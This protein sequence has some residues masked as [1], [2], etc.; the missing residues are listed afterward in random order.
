VICIS[1][2]N[3]H[4]RC[5]WGIKSGPSMR[6]VGSVFRLEFRGFCLCP[7]VGRRK[8]RCLVGTSPHAPRLEPYLRLSPHTAQ[9]L[10][11]VSMAIPMKR[12][13]PFLQLHGTFSVFSLR[14]RWV[15]LFPSFRRLGTFAFSSRPSVRGF[16]ALRLL[17]PFRHSSFICV[18]D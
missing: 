1:S 5:S 17:R 7:L 18:P 12:L 4:V 3:V 10:R 11:S 14:V 6:S 2:I 9:H 8:A 15:P 16:P 13:F